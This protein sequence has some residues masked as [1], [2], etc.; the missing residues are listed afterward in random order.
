MLITHFPWRPF[1]SSTLSAVGWMDEL[2]CP[3]LES[4][5]IPKPPLSK[6]MLPLQMWLLNNSPGSLSKAICPHFSLPPARSCPAV[7]V[8]AWLCILDRLCVHVRQTWIMSAVTLLKWTPQLLATSQLQPL[9]WYFLCFQNYFRNISEYFQNYIVT[10]LN[11]EFWLINSFSL[12]SSQEE[13][14]KYWP[15]QFWE[16]CVWRQNANS[17]KDKLGDGKWDSKGGNVGRVQA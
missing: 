1:A 15:G 7:P 4:S 3:T 11:V 13:P 14:K 16:G 10:S 2:E 6:V 9:L 17:I 5:L 12:S 8:K